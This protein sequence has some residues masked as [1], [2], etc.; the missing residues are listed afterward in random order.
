MLESAALLLQVPDEVRNK[1]KQLAYGLL[2]GKGARALSK[3]LSCTIDEAQNER[4]TFKRS[5]P[6][7]VSA[8]H[9]RVHPPACLPE[10]WNDTAVAAWPAAAC[11]QRPD[12]S[13]RG[14]IA[15]V[16]RLCCCA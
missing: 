3:D 6:G 8:S 10:S 12:R 16:H 4:D 15:L 2:Y 11:L 14:V 5:L 9:M 13:G 7:V 1:A